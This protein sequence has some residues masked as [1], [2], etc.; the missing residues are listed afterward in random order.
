MEKVCSTCKN[1]RNINDFYKNCRSKD[2]H[3]PSCKLCAKDKKHKLYLLN[4]DKYKNK[5]KEYHLLNKDDKDI[6]ERKSK[7]YHL[8]KD[9]WLAASKKFRNNNPEKWSAYN[10]NWRT[11]NSDKVSLNLAKRRAAKLNATPKWAN[12]KMIA[13]WY[14]CAKSSSKISGFPWHVDHIVPL[15]GKI[16]GVQVVC[17]LHW[18]GNFQL[19]P[20][21]ENQSKG[22][23][24]WPDM[25][26]V[27]DDAVKKTYDRV[28]KQLV[29][30]T[31]WSS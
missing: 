21:S 28:T 4:S 22:N 14:K 15:M 12:N 13:Y 27:L 3:D 20:G 29:G 25:P 30:E 16:N 2:G 8:N 18:E 6:F 23:R 5:S 24:W 17:G 11:N 31:S 26:D 7:Y 9:K 1:L 10:K 19:L